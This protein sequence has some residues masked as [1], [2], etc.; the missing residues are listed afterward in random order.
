[1]TNNYKYLNIKDLELFAKDLPLIKN[2]FEYLTFDEFSDPFSKFIPGDDLIILKKLYSKA[3]ALEDLDMYEKALKV[4]DAFDNLLSRY[5][6]FEAISHCESLDDLLP[7]FPFNLSQKDLS[8]LKILYDLAIYCEKVHEVLEAEKLWR[9]ISDLL[10]PYWKAY[11][12]KNA[13]C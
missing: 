9:Q 3:I 13:V 7:N 6:K 8:T 11:D 12:S 1:M 10:D 4:W 2:S 5:I